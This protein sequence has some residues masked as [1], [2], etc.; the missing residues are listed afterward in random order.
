[1]SYFED[2]NS[3]SAMFESDGR[4]EADFAQTT[5]EIRDFFLFLEDYRHLSRQYATNKAYWPEDFSGPQWYRDGSPVP[6]DL[7]W[8]GFD[9]DGS[10]T[11]IID[12]IETGAFLAL[13][14]GHGKSYGWH[15]PRFSTS[16]SDYE[17]KLSDLHNGNLTPVVLSFACRTGWF[18]HETDED[19][20][21]ETF[22]DEESFAEQFLRMEGGAVAV[23]AASR[24]SRGGVNEDMARAFIDGIWN[25]M[26]PGYPNAESIAPELEGSHRLGDVLNYAKFYIADQYGR[27]DDPVQDFGITQVM[28]EVFHLFGDPTME[29]WTANPA[30]LIDESLLEEIPMRPL[31]PLGLSYSLPIE[32]DGVVVTLLHNGEILGQGI[33]QDG[34][35]I[36]VLDQ[37]LTSAE[38]LIITI[39]KTGYLTQKV[40]ILPFGLAPK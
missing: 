36:I 3:P 8:P 34:Q 29:L 33:S 16:G 19:S 13:Y 15:T 17:L 38:D 25:H 30:P 11:G 32:V 12:E 35:A 5:E 39:T 1:M 26:L 6:G 10:A 37:P 7:R 28:F 21:S 20:P 22:G 2:W 23:V 31:W 27:P 9:W 18:D 4:D 24:N 40:E 14:I